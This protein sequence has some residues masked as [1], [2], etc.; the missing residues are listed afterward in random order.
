VVVGYYNGSDI[1]TLDDDASPDRSD[2]C[3]VEGLAA[4][5]A[6]VRADARFTDRCTV[7]CRRHQVTLEPEPQVVSSL[8]AEVNDLAVRLGVTGLRVLRSGHSVDVVGDAASKRRVVEA[9][10]ERMADG[11]LAVLCVGDRGRWPG[12]D[13]EL[14]ALP[15]SL[16][17][18]EVSTD[19]QTCWNFAPPGVRGVEAALVYLKAL[20]ARG[21]RARLRL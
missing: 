12:N 19:P 9:V 13:C 7:T 2:A 1:A 11:E 16:S 14:L 6:A 10:A 4:L 8:W 21:G 20:T 5:A 15:H 3:A 18:D 17:V